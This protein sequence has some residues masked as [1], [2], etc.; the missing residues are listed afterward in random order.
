MNGVEQ[1]ETGTRK[2]DFLSAIII[3]MTTYLARQLKKSGFPDQQ[4]LIISQ[5]VINEVTEP[6]K[7]YYIY[8]VKDKNCTESAIFESTLLT[9]L[10][11]HGF[12][13]EKADLVCAEIIN[14][15]HLQFGGRSIYIALGAYMN[16]KAATARN[17]QII[18]EYRK[19]TTVRDLMGKYGL[20]HT[21]IYDV[22]NGKRSRKD[23][24]KTRESVE[25]RI[26]ARNGT[27]IKRYKTDPSPATIKRLARGYALSVSSIYSI[28]WKAKIMGSERK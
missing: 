3:E 1:A 12:K 27:I 25:K 11:R 10:L 9:L 22:V 6:Y 14:N 16:K 5:A 20:S 15:F 26:A 23:H 24:S 7:G 13:K 28:L 4:S 21:R 17:E 8:L 19:G 2:A 18:S